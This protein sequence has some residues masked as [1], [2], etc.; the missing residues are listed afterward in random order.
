MAKLAI[1]LCVSLCLASASAAGIRYP[2]VR[3][4]TILAFDQLSCFYRLYQSRF[5]TI[6]FAAARLLSN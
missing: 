5:L 2:Q 1:A 6:I 4:T 3:S